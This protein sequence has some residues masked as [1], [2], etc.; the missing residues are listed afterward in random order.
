ME[1][2]E[3]GSVSLFVSSLDLLIL[4]VT[5]CSHETMDLIMVPFYLL[6]YFEVCLI[7]L[8]LSFVLLARWDHEHRDGDVP[9]I[10]RVYHG[11]VACRCGLEKTAR[12]GHQVDNLQ[13]VSPTRSLARC[14]L[15]SNVTYLAAPAVANNTPVLDTR[16]GGLQFIHDLL[17][18]VDSLRWSRG[19]L[20]ELA[21]FLPLFLRVWRIPRDVGRLAFEEIRHE[22]PEVVVIV[23]MCEYVG[24]LDGL[25]KEAKDVVYDQNS[26][27]SG[28]G[29]GCVCSDAT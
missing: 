10:I 8:H 6:G 20:E 28:R 27:L 18:T 3:Q 16:V 9:R 4:Q 13:M 15:W 26:L 12:G 23:R 21:Q 1:P 17:D 29:A 24:A 2:I 14:L 22:D 5:S 7:L 19:C 11:R 25:G